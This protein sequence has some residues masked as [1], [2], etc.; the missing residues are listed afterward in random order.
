MTERPPT[1]LEFRLEGDPKKEGLVL[2]QDFVAFLGSVLDTLKKL[3]LERGRKPSISYRIV[4]LEIGSAVVALEPEGEEAADA[5]AILS[6]FLEGFAAVRDRTLHTRRFS[7]ATQKAFRSLAK[8]LKESH[9]RLISVRS[10]SIDLE[11]RPDSGPALRALGVPDVHAMGEISG[12]IDA[13]NVHREPVFFLYPEVGPSR[14]R[15]VFDRPL[16]DDV[17]SALKRFVT[18]RGMVEYPEGSPFATRVTVEH[19]DVHPR[20]PDLVPLEA[21]FGSVPDLTGGLDS[22]TFVRRQRDAED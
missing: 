2:A 12:Y 4:E 19:V 20:E 1:R 14:V 3:E 10:D 11:L 7:P 22:V 21:I 17:R 8:P 9:L 16:L 15:C 13:I 18:V 6:D 5:Q